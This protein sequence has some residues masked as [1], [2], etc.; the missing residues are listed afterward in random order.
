MR[1]WEHKWEQ[2]FLLYAYKLFIISLLYRQ[3]GH[4]GINIRTSLRE[5]L[6]RQEH[7]GSYQRTKQS[8]KNQS[9][10]PRFCRWTSNRPKK[11]L[12][13]NLFFN[14]KDREALF[15]RQSHLKK[16]N[17]TLPANKVLLACSRTFYLSQTSNFIKSLNHFYPYLSSRKQ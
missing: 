14:W 3:W 5:K 7:S 8:F 2:I 4:E 13:K 1:A 6:I 11:P 12:F 10:S 9:P 15:T 17:K 16:R